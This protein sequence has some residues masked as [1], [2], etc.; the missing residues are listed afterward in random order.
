MKLSANKLTLSAEDLDYSN[1]ANEVL[2]CDY[3]GKDMEIGF[4]A[5]LVSEL[6]SNLGAKFVDIKL[7][8]PNKAGLIIPSDQDENEDV[9]LL[10]MPVMLN[11]YN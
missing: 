1:E 5:K 9:L 8:E 6:L 10:V 7:S 11:S 4:N 3:A 2:A